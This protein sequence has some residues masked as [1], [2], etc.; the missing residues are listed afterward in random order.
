MRHFKDILFLILTTIFTS[1]QLF[2]QA[3]YYKINSVN[4]LSYY[5]KDISGVIFSM[6]KD[7]PNNTQLSIAIIE[8]GKIL[9]N[10]VFK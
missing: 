10:C 5:P 6:T 2:A 7:L 1:N 8:N 4:V 9:I 3:E